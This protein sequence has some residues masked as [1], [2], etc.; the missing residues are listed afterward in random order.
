MR[1]CM[2]SALA[3]EPSN[4]RPSAETQSKV[5]QHHGMLWHIKYPKG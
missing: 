1:G 2:K 4:H 3:L 5:L